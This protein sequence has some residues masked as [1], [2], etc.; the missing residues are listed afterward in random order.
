MNIEL[1]EQEFVNVFR[2]RLRK[3]GLRL[4]YTPGGRT[5]KPLAPFEILTSA[6]ESV[7]FFTSLDDLALYC[8]FLD[9]EE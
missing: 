7:Q 2:G 9:E 6:G 8:E 5:R 1:T 3:H 4:Q